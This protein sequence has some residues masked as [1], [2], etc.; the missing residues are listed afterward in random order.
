MEWLRSDSFD[1]I[2]LQ[3]VRALPEQLDERFLTELSGLNC[4]WNPAERKG[5]SGVA[6]LSKALPLKVHYGIRSEE[7]D[8]EGRVLSA[9]FKELIVVSA[10]FP[11]SQDAGARLPYKL[12]FCEALQEW[13]KYLS[14]QKKAVVLTGDFNIAHQAID[15]ARPAENERTA[16][17][18][19]EERE[20][21]SSF[22]KSGW[23]DTYRHFSPTAVDQYSWWSARMRA[24]ERNVGW[25]IDYHCVPEHDR[26][27]LVAAG[28]SQKVL[29]SDHCPVTLEIDAAV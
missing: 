25:R 23:V 9:E 20:W 14:R 6:I 19:P 21:M 17:Y 16:G 5:Y 22:L 24:R 8:V 26:S 3:E 1:V 18:L 7:F 12:K 29:G 2:A 15:L 10:Y 11:N 27:K 4:L 13:V 28:I